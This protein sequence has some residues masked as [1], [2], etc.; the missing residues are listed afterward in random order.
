MSWKDRIEANPAVL[1]GKPIIKS[2]HIS[3]ELILDRRADGWAM[4]DVMAFS[5]RTA[6]PFTY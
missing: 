2:T 1:V 3:V 5:V 4:E 6:G